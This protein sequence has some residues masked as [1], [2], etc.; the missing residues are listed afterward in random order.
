MNTRIL[1]ALALTAS[2][3]SLLACAHTGRKDPNP[4]PRTTIVITN[5]GSTNTIGYRIVI[6][7]DG[8]AS[9]ASGEGTG[10]AT[11]PLPILDQ[12]D[13]DVAAAA[14]LATL[15]PG[16]GCARSV[17]FGTSTFIAVGSDRS[18]DLTCAGNEIA[19]KVKTDI[20]TV[21]EYLNLHNVP[22]S[23]G[24]PLPPEE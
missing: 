18:P 22:R 15:P 23:T 24:K 5:S 4:A 21:V 7:P 17:S 14:P 8:Q 10:V 19:Q 9:F 3:L 1:P 11:M 13:A 16:S 20:H 12:L 6:A 2:L